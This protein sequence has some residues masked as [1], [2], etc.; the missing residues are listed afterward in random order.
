LYCSKVLGILQNDKL[1]EMKTFENYEDWWIF[2]GV[3]GSRFWFNRHRLS[4][5]SNLY[6]WSVPPC[7]PLFFFFKS[8]NAGQSTAFAT[9]LYKS[10]TELYQVGYF[11]ALFK[12]S[13]KSG[14][15]KLRIWSESFKLQCS[16][17]HWVLETLNLILLQ[18]IHNI[19]TLK[20]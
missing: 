18:L 12:T 11:P 14:L 16:V 8:P 13:V 20:H 4:S 5:L 6:K 7:P 1:R 10:I 2:V 19:H 9:Y 15:N 3:Y 17:P